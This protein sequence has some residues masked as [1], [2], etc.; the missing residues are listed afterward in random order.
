MNKDSK[1]IE[2]SCKEHLMNVVKESKNLDKKLSFFQKTLLYDKIKEMKY[3]KV[4]GLLFNE[5]KEVTQEQKRE[6][7][8]KTKKAAKYGTAMVV[9]SAL[10]HVATGKMTKGGFKGA[11]GA[12]AALYLYR[13]LSEPCVRKNLGNR[14]NQ[15]TCKMDAI[16]QVM[17]QI[18][19]D[20]GKCNVAADPI[21]CRKKLSN[22]LVKWQVKYQQYL[23]QVTKLKRKK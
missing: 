6:F 19:V 21:K 4:I 13:K 2:V 11:L 18:K 8:S 23:I 22:E 7:E 20:M 1:L 14:Q 12:V 15:I 3:E 5:G 9:G 17:D 16:K 10:G